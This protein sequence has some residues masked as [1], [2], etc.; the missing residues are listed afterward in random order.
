MLP[1]KQVQPVLQ[2]QLLVLLGR[3]ARVIIHNLVANID[4]FRAVTMEAVMTMLVVWCSAKQVE[5]A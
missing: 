5:H 2:V 3:L 1:W 4:D